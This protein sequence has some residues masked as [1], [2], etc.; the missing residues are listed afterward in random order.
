MDKTQKIAL[1][2]IT[3][4]IFIGVVIIVASGGGLP[5]VRQ[6]TFRAAPGKQLDT[7][8]PLVSETAKEGGVDGAPPLPRQAE[9]SATTSLNQGEEERPLSVSHSDPVLSPE[10]KAVLQ[11]RNAVNPRTGVEIIEELLQSLENLG[12]ASELY[13][14]K[15][16]LCL[17]L[18]PPDLEEASDAADEALN[19][20]AEPEDRDQAGYVRADVLRRAGDSEGAERAAAAVVAAEGPLTA[21]K[22]RAGFLQ[23]EIRRGSGDGAS[24][25]AGYRNIMERIAGAGMLGDAQSR[26]FYRQAALNLVQMLRASGRREEAD[27][28][29]EEA[30]E[31]LSRFREGK[32]R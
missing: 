22:L 27:A 2:L 25:T 9:G 6:S 13:A 30:K 12:K 29:A 19:Y 1:A 14:A 28:V 18:T 4:G 32:N 17:R 26:D 24:A 31:Q 15:A 5:T 23:A 10:D 21:G 7:A 16:E 3:A 20:A 11:A 8:R